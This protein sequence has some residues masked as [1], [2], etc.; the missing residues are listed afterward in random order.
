MKYKTKSWAFD[1]FEYDPH[2][3]KPDWWIN[4]VKNG[5]AFEYAGLNNSLP[6]A[7]F[8]DKRSNHKAFI[9]DFIVRDQ[10][11]RIDVYSQRNF[12]QRSR[13]DIKDN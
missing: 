1:A 9:G 4:L 10:F 12:A 5:Q 3:Y 8:S 6:H 11:G 2:G 7:G 13:L